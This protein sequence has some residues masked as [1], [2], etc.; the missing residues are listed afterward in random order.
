[1]LTSEYIMP[2]IVNALLL[3]LRYSSK[4]A[5]S[6]ISQDVN[7][8]QANHVC[9]YNHNQAISIRTLQMFNDTFL[10]RPDKIWACCVRNDI[11]N[12]RLLCT[13]LDDGFFATAHI[14]GKLRMI[15]YRDFPL[16]IHRCSIS[17]PLFR[18][19]SIGSPAYGSGAVPGTT[20]L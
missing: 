4:E 6:T 20:L 16:I 19:G 3:Y 18:H 5:N 7:Q 17:I 8:S 10:T 12:L 9:L 2:C 11:C 13:F 1:M 15:I 14:Q